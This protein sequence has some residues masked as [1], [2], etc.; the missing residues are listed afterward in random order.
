MRLSKT[1]LLY[2]IL[3]AKQS[4]WSFIQIYIDYSYLDCS[5][6]D[7]SYIDYSYID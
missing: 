3:V 4:G 6:I 1:A 5:Y 7:Y 2:F